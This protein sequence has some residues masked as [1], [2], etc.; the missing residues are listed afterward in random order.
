[1][2]NWKSLT[3]NLAISL[4]T[5]IL[6]ALI[7]RNSM[8]TYKNLNLPKLAP[9]S[10]LFPIVWTILFILMGISA[11][12]IYE[13]NSDQK[14]NALTIYGIQLLVNFI[15]PILFFNLELY[16]FSFVWIILLWLLIIL[17][18]NSF[19][20]ISNVA[21]YLQIPYLLWV[22]FA[23]YLNFMIYYNN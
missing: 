21:A 5:G 8:D 17:M 14:Q 6:S 4:G 13:S 10:I 7:T 1:M 9:P 18:I 16:L 12:I 3:A 22:T 15:W 23:S 20:K 11:Y 19:K 2:I